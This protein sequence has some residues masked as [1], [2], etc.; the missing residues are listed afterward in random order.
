MNAELIMDA[1]S[2]FRFLF[3]R[4]FVLCKSLFHLF[5]RFRTGLRDDVCGI[6]D[7]ERLV[8]FIEPGQVTN[9]T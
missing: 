9:A 7:W 2:P 5:S 6:Y 4:I 1:I 8:Y 3:S